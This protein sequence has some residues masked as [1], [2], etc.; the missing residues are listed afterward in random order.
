M[1]SNFTCVWMKTLNQVEKQHFESFWGVERRD[2]R[3][4][5]LLETRAKNLSVVLRKF[6]F[7]NL[8]SRNLILVI[9]STPSKVK[10]YCLFTFQCGFICVCTC[11]NTHS[12]QPVLPVNLTDMQINKQTAIVSVVFQLKGLMQLFCFD[13][14]HTR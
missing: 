3:N 9:S 13:Y 5:S 8:S 1:I 4:K 7:F 12:T 2:I 6:P 14:S 11:Q 10:T